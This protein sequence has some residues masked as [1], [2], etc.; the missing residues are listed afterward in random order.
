M[1][2]F[3]ASNS[4][5]TTV[6]ALRRWPHCLGHGLVFL[7]PASAHPNGA[8]HFSAP[9]SQNASGKDNAFDVPSGLAGLNVAFR[10]KATESVSS[11]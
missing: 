5:N 3:E 4:N 9:F 1:R 7:A 6:A 10:K 2:R 11:P 8:Y